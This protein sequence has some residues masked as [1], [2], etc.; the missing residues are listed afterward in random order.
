M[1]GSQEG[2]Q[3][4]VKSDQQPIMDISQCKQ[5]LINLVVLWNWT[6]RVVICWVQN[7]NDIDMFCQQLYLL[8]TD[9]RHW[10]ELVNSIDRKI[11]LRE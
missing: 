1:V 11:G 5:W 2:K 3:D 8:Y 9:V 10:E 4:N 6:F 7:D